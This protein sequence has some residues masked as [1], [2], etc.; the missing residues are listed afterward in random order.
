MR[1]VNKKKVMGNIFLEAEKQKRFIWNYYG[2]LLGSQRKLKEN[3]EE[4]LE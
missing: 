2:Q 4:H 3:H 1:F